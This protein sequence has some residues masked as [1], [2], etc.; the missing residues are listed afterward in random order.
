MKP[1]LPQLEN[2]MVISAIDFMGILRLAEL[3]L[4]TD[5]NEMVQQFSSLDKIQYV[6]SL[7]Y[8]DN[9]DMYP[10]DVTITVKHKS[11]I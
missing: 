6:K 5:D 1:A 11:S 7:V 10:T 2:T 3:M 9:E 8:S 4:L